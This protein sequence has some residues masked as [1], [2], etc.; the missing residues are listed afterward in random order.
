MLIRGVAAALTAV[1]LAAAF[2]PASAQ[3]GEPPQE[4]P[5]PE[6]PLSDEALR[7]RLALALAAAEYPVTPGDTYRL[8]FLPAIAARTDAAARVSETVVVA[9]DYTVDLGAFGT[10][11]G[12]GLNLIELRRRVAARVAD[13]Y[14]GSNPALRLS[15]VG[16]FEVHLRGAVETSGHTA[17]WGLGRLSDVVEERLSPHASVRDLRVERGADVL[18]FDLFRAQR[19]GN[20]SQDPYL[21]PGDRICVSRHER[22]VRINGQV[23]R[24]GSYQL[25]EGEGLAE[26]VAFAGGF[27]PWADL[28]RVRV[29]SLGAAPEA[30]PETAE[31]ILDCE[32]APLPAASTYPAA[33]PGATRY[34]AW[35]AGL[36]AAALRDGDVVTI[37]NRDALLPA[38]FF[39]GAVVEPMVETSATG[40]AAEATA[41]GEE[42]GARIAHRYRPGETLFDALQQNLD[43]I[44]PGADL[45]NATLVRRGEPDE[46]IDLELLLH[47][48]AQGGDRPLQPGDRIVIPAQRFE[49]A[50][51]GEVT[52]ARQLTVS[53]VTRLHEVVAQ[54][55]TP[56]TSLRRIVVAPPRGP[57]R[58]YDLFRW[59]RFGEL[60][61]NPLLTPGAAITFHARDREVRVSGEVRRPG[62]YQILPGEGLEELIEQYGDGFTAAA[63]PG[64]VVLTRPHTDGGAREAIAVDFRTDAGPPLLDGDE[65]VVRPRP[66][67]VVYVEGGLRPPA[68]TTV[69]TTRSGAHEEEVTT[70]TERTLVRDTPVTRTT[71]RVVPYWPGVTVFDVLFPLR[72]DLRQDAD[73]EA[74]YVVRAGTR[75]RLNLQALLFGGERD[76]DLPLQPYDTIVV[77]VRRFSVTVAGAV[78]SPGVY[79]YLPGRPA[80][81]YVRLAGGSAAAGGASAVTVTD[82]MGRA[83]DPSAPVAPDDQ[84]SVAADNLL[85]TRVLAPAATLGAL[86]ISFVALILALD[87]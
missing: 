36:A 78:Q 46:A 51:R 70:A 59:L 68:A 45:A 69:T 33:A 57:Q 34:A 71:R 64:R 12:R 8:S 7:Q 56:Y 17:T 38:V 60:A 20:R 30:V 27:T 13:A 1:L 61:H 47:G 86:V 32:G 41:T 55:R 79:A 50:L 19:F 42:S 81:Y 76:R 58:T 54:V 6:E 44:A 75:L 4:R 63:N 22:A 21:L 26:L 48:G 72:G 82:G 53:P 85:F 24:P 2:A 10:L 5:L 37:A 65:V 49:V 43:A 18:A 15:E 73:L 52:E 9:G 66:A 11:N 16:T 62:R 77:P 67:P 74:G 29:E 39:E 3:Q 23:W 40:A 35:D 80:E 84:I 25:A 83:K 31:P 14:P 87:S 28:E